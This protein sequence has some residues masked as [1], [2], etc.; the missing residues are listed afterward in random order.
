MEKYIFSTRIKLFWF[1]I[2]WSRWI[3]KCHAPKCWNSYWRVKCTLQHPAAVG[4]EFRHHRPNPF[5][6]WKWKYAFSALCLRC[7]IWMGFDCLCVAVDVQVT[8]H[9]TPFS[10]WSANLLAF[11]E[12]KI[13]GIL[14]HNRKAEK[15]IHLLCD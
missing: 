11:H 5:G 13:V 4:V 3:T 12:Y 2:L 1:N 6:V 9:S 8:S 10:V 7:H 15:V 14:I